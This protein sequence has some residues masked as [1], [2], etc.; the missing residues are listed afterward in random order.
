MQHAIDAQAD[1]EYLLVGFEMDIRSPLDDGVVEDQID[2]LDGRGVL[3]DSPSL[4]PIVFLGFHHLDR[5][6]FAQ[7]DLV[8]ELLGLDAGGRSVILVD[9]LE[10]R[11]FGG[12][13]RLDAQVGGKPDFF[14]DEQ[15]GG[16]GHGQGQVGAD[17]VDG[18]DHVFAGDVGLD[19]LDHLLVDF[20]LATG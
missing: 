8:Q 16:I 12:D 11:R 14:L 19:Q 9:G 17:A 2:Q 1:A 3:V 6:V 10:D 4:M 20:E 15:V 7:F 5:G 13:H 18:D